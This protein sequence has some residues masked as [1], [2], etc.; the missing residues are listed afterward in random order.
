MIQVFNILSQY[1]QDTVRN[2]I[3][4]CTLCVVTIVKRRQDDDRA[5]WLLKQE[6]DY[7]WV[8]QMETMTYNAYAPTAHITVRPCRWVQLRVK[9]S[10]M[11]SDHAIDPNIVLAA[12]REI[13]TIE[14]A[15]KKPVLVGIQEFFV[16]EAIGIQDV[17]ESMGVTGKA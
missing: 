17:L 14:G 1:F 5:R 4:P 8:I 6:R 10:R 7:A 13:Q 15:P 9:A 12:P 3:E 11:I 2:S 16:P